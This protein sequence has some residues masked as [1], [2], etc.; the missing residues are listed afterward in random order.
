MAVITAICRALGLPLSEPPVPSDPLPAKG[1]QHRQ[2]SRLKRLASDPLAARRGWPSGSPRTAY[3][4]AAIRG[5]HPACP[6][7]LHP[8][9]RASP[10]LGIRLAAITGSHVGDRDP[11]ASGLREEARARLE[12]AARRLRS[13]ATHRPASRGAD[14]ADAARGL[15][16]G[17][18]RERAPAPGTRPRRRRQLTRQRD[19]ERVHRPLCGGGPGIAFAGDGGSDPATQGALVPGSSPGQDAGAPQLGG[20]GAGASPAPPRDSSAFATATGGEMRPCWLSGSIRRS[21]MPSV[22]RPFRWPTRA[23]KSQSCSRG[24]PRLFAAAASRWC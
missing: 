8:A 17:R 10:P 16:G 24:P 6:L 21:P 4:P 12:R 23:T 20:E 2:G 3:R 22:F 1:L 11:T 5:G 13:R 19:R 7:G 18:L 9:R 15:L 14:A